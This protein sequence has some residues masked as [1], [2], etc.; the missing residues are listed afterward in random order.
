MNLVID[1]R[2]FLKGT[3]GFLAVSFLLPSAVFA[4]QAAANAGPTLPG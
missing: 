4:Q 2:T 1:R 3:G